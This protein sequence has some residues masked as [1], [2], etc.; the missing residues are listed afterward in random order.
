MRLNYKYIS[1]IIH[2]NYHF[3][4]KPTIAVAV[5]G[6]PDSMCLLF[7]LNEWIKTNCGKIIALIVNHNLRANSTSEANG[8][9]KFLLS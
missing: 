4:K 6:G 3:E 2:K 5:S 9:L 1:E 8:I 7:L